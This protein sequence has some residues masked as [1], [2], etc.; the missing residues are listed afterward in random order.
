[1]TPA[2]LSRIGQPSRRKRLLTDLGVGLACWL[3][4]AAVMAVVYVLGSPV[5]P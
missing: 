5:K 4:I 2:A 3:L 1:M